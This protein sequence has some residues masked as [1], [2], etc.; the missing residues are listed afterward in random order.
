ME[1]LG[2]ISTP[3][4][5]TCLDVVGINMNPLTGRSVSCKM[6]GNV[7]IKMQLNATRK[8]KLLSGW[9][10]AKRK[11]SQYERSIVQ[12]GQ[13]QPAYEIW[14]KRV[15]SKLATSAKNICM[16]SGF[17]QYSSAWQQ[18]MLT[19]HLSLSQRLIKSPSFC[20]GW[21]ARSRGKQFAS[22]KCEARFNHQL[23]R[24]RF[25]GC[26]I[27]CDVAGVHLIKNVIIWWV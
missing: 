13:E 2:N 9:S 22:V 17:L 3:C 19:C 23:R 16:T 25:W 8:S 11:T 10:A 14:W 27:G 20:V 6:N 24:V 5:H 7:L 21:N 4:Q 1:S 18:H 12:R 15:T 26:A